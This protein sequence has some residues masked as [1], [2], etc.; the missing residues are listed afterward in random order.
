MDRLISSFARSR[1]GRFLWTALSI[2]A[3]SIV[4]VDLA[5]LAAD[6]A[7]AAAKPAADKPDANK[8]DANQPNVE[9]SDSEAPKPKPDPFP[10]PPLP[11]LKRLAPSAQVWIDLPNKQLVM[12]GEV[13][14]RRGPLELFACLKNTKEHEA[15]VSIQ[16]KAYI[17]HA[18]L[19]ACGAVTGNPAK[20]V[21]EYTPAR[22]T[23]VEVLVEWIDDAG[24][25]QKVDAR[26]WIKNAKTGKA[27]ESPWVFGGS[28]FWVDP[29]DNSRHYQA[30]DGD[31][32]CISNFPSA[33]LDVPVE[34][35]NANASLLFE[36]FTANIPADKTK[37]LIYLKPKLDKKPAAG[38]KPAPAAPKSGDVG[39]TPA[40]KEVV[41]QAA[42]S[43]RADATA[44]TPQADAPVV[45]VAKTESTPPA[46]TKPEESGSAPAPYQA[47]T[48]SSHRTDQTPRIGRW[49]RRS[50]SYRRSL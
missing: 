43:I 35:S 19:L 45:P 21:P 10:D 8:T 28:G 40:T 44:A 3:A 13:V 39:A 22:G 48:H 41:A 23:E 34:S 20:F 26:Q 47:S 49:L 4:M 1:R 38:D 29:A 7:P 9:S 15:V 16:T 17:V 14:L 42:T 18:G 50:A 31:L 12:K 11:G 5:A 37:V 2:A 27:M 32:I 6:T 24:K 33:M 25:K 36:A 30:E 46:T